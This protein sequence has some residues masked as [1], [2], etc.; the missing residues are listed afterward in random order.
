MA[1]PAPKID[2][3]RRQF[4][5]RQVALPGHIK[6]IGRARIPCF[7]R[8]ISASGAFIELSDD[9]QLPPQFRLDIDGDLFETMC[10]L[11]HQSGRHF[12]VEF[13]SNRQGALAL[14]GG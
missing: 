10:E 3:D 6:I 11:K 4:A 7:V 12:G 13:T 9:I 14:Y 5:R 1:N 8:N 2:A